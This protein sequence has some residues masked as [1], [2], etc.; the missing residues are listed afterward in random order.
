MSLRF[1]ARIHDHFI[2]NPSTSR[3]WHDRQDVVEIFEKGAKVSSLR[4]NLTNVLLVHTR[5]ISLSVLY[6]WF[7]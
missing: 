1:S 3:V 2:D 7:S 5:L 6:V 4:H